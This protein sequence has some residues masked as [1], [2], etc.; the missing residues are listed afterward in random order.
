MDYMGAHCWV[1]TYYATDA[2]M[3]TRVFGDVIF[4]AKHGINAFTRLML[5]EEVDGVQRRQLD[6][7]NWLGGGVN[8]LLCDRR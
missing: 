1:V 3:D 5:G 8:T 6:T 4:P 2:I 7:G